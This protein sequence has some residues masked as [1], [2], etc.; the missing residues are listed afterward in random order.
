MASGRRP[1]DAEGRGDT[2]PNPRPKPPPKIVFSVHMVDRPV[3]LPTRS[4]SVEASGSAVPRPSG[5]WGPVV[6]GP[7]HG[8]SGGKTPRPA[9]RAAS[10]SSRS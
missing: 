2:I 3:N 9:R 5:R 8:L 4:E 10:H 1:D 6:E 7:P